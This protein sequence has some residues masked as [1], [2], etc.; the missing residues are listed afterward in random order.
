MDIFS[1][2]QGYCYSFRIGCGTLKLADV[3][4]L[5][6]QLILWQDI[7]LT[8]SIKLN[9]LSR[10]TQQQTRARTTTHIYLPTYLPFKMKSSYSS[11]DFPTLSLLPPQARAPRSSGPMMHR[12]TCSCGGVGEPL[13]SSTLSPIPSNW[14][15]T[16]CCCYC[17]SSL[18]SSTME[19]QPSLTDILTEALAIAE[20]TGAMMTASRE[21]QQQQPP[22]RDGQRHPTT[23]RNSTNKDRRN[24]DRE[25]PK[26]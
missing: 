26:Q 4:S 23:T 19:L 13:A 18:S 20:V 9:S 25:G 7:S 5:S 24:D 6:H 16:P 2:F 12:N 14:M 8:A 11:P 15:M 17:E 10:A 22:S 21:R 3:H 1:T